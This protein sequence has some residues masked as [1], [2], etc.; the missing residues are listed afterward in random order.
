[1]PKIWDDTI[2]THRGAVL[3]AIFA[4]TGSIVGEEGLT[5]L[6]MSRVAADAG[7]G[8]ATLYKYFNDID[9]VLVAWHRHAI[10]H[11]MS[12]LRH[13]SEQHGDALEALKAVLFAFAD[14]RSSHGAHDAARLLHVLPHVGDAEGRL[15]SF[16]GDLIAAAR[17]NG[18][19][20]KDIAPDDL[21]AFAISSL[22]APHT[23]AFTPKLVD[24]VLTAMRRP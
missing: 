1:M 12:M 2:E 11:H 10:E 4:A 14:I 21:A 17:K 8:R 24:L 5:A 9:A 19:F 16:L 13:I 22:S 7:I 3:E 15:R 18:S 20:R 6:S 23:K